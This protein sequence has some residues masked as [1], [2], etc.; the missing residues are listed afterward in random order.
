MATM[1]TIQ[2]VLR[3]LLVARFFMGLGVYPI[4][5]SKLKIQWIKYLSIVYILV[6]WLAYG[7][8]FYY[9]VTI[10][11]IKVIFRSINHKIIVMINILTTIISVI[12]SQYYQKVLYIV[13]ILY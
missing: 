12:M 7:Y 10:F 3:P 2:Q 8:L 5:Q 1:V 4:K 13:L 11:T 9:S 6:I